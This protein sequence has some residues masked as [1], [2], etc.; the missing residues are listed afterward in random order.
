MMAARLAC[1]WIIYLGTVAHI[2]RHHRR[3]LSLF[4]LGLCLLGYFLDHD[5]PIPSTL[6]IALK[7]VR[8]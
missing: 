3:D 1:L 4:Q 8:E 6:H 5:L 2:H 7:S